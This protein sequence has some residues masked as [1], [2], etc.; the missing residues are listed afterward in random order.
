MVRD[1]RVALCRRHSRRR[2]ARSTAAVPLTRVTSAVCIVT[3]SRTR[4]TYSSSSIDYVLTTRACVTSFVFITQDPI[5]EFTIVNICNLYVYSRA[6]TFPGT[7]KTFPAAARANSI[8]R[9]AST[10]DASHARTH[11]GSRARSP[12]LSLSRSLASRVSVSKTLDHERWGKRRRRHR[13]PRWT[14]RVWARS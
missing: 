4:F 5:H 14:T 7:R 1:R 8:P 12:S 3:D 10:T 6:C 11:R 9:L 2:S 13:R